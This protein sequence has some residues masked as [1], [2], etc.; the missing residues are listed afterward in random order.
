[1]KILVTGTAGAIGSHVAERLAS[2]GHQVIGVDSFDDYYDI[3]IKQ[4]NSSEVEEKGVVIYTRDLSKDDIFDLVEATDVIFHFA[5][6]P[7]ISA[8]TTLDRYMDNNVRATHRLLEAARRSERLK[9]FFHISTS[10]VYGAYA[11]GDET[12]EPHP[13]SDYGRTKLAAEQ[14]AMAYHQ[15]EGVPVSVLR[16]FSVYGER[17]RPE[18]FFHKLIRAIYA[19]EDV[20]LYEG[21]DRHLRSFTHVSDVVD[22]CVLALGDLDAVRGEIF[23]VGNDKT[24]TTGEG[25]EIIEGII[26][27]KAK[28]KTMPRRLGDQQETSANIT[29]IRTVLGYEPKVS[30]K[31]GLSRQVKWYR[32]KIL[33]RR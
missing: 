22:A 25:I 9:M 14:L 24:S 10:S 3:E 13:I 17:E 7:G 19:D 5:A 21:S 23:N 15:D 33:G 32:T 31:E 2:L 11:N 30:L 28:I 20:P 16:L 12:A 1:M 26:G 29:K 6:Q 18:K 27:K 4:M 8:T